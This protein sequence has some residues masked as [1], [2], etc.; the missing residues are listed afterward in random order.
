MAFPYLH[1]NVSQ[2]LYKLALSR[3]P[4]GESVPKS[5][6]S[7]SA[8]ASRDTQKKKTLARQSSRSLPSPLTAEATYRQCSADMFNFQDTSSFTTSHDIISQDRAVR[9][10]N[11]GLGIRKPGYN[12]YVAG[13][14]G[15]GK[16]SVIR[17]FLEKWSA[18][19]PSPNDWV[20]VFD[21]NDPEAPK[22]IALEAGGGRRLKKAMEALVKNL[23]EVIPSALQSEDYENAVNAYISASNERKAKLYADLEKLA[24]SMD[25]II[26]QNCHAC[27][28]YCC[29]RYWHLLF[30]FVVE[31]A[32][33]STSV[34]WVTA[35]IFINN[36]VIVV[37]EVNN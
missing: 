31:V 22:A 20:Y 11:M 4:L 7:K 23:K 28:I 19:S 10:I 33:K 1:P 5:S 3:K 13:I 24:K 2:L 21:F 30:P 32:D 35:S 15:T 16:T 36:C 14:Q 9:A 29:G 26:K 6:P 18:H 27:F 17:T 8:A 34:Y 25:F 37:K 12:I